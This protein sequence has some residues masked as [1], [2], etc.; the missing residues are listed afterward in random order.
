MEGDYPVLIREGGIHGRTRD[1][2][3]SEYENKHQYNYEQRHN[4][5]FDPFQQVVDK[6]IIVIVLGDSCF[7][8]FIAHNAKPHKKHLVIIIITKPSP[9]FKWQNGKIAK[10]ADI[11]L[12]IKATG[13]KFLQNKKDIAVCD[14]LN[15]VNYLI[16][17]LI[18]AALPTL[19]LR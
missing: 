17:S 19:F 18:L 6:G 12:C 7:I 11:F 3:D 8:Y 5:S 13:A 9:L 15:A 4:E 1:L 16:I 10:T 14:A 2:N